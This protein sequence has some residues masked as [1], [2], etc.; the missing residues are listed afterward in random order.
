MQTMARTGGGAAPSFLSRVT[1]PAPVAGAGRALLRLS[2]PGCAPGV[3]AKDRGGGARREDPPP[4]SFREGRHHGVLPHGGGKTP[5]RGEGD[6]P[7][8]G[9]ERGRGAGSATSRPRGGRHA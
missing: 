6:R 4:A 5:P 9:S 1:T 8:P 2:S 7:S 3:P